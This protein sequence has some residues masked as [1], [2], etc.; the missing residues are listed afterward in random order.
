MIVWVNMLPE[1]KD[2][3][4][5]AL[6]N[7][8]YDPRVRWF[9]DPL[10]RAGKVIA[11]IL[12]APNNTAWDIYLFFDPKAQ[13][14]GE[15]PQPRSWVHQLGDTWADPTRYRTGEQLSVELANLLRDLGG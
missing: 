1:D 15:P 7:L 8:M 12:G 11:S 14:K 13:W 2:A 5:E 4:R 6:S 9:N 3:D 10:C